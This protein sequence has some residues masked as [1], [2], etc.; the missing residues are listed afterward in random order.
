MPSFP[1]QVAAKANTLRPARV[2]LSV[3]VAPFYLLGLIVGVVWVLVSWS[4]AAVMLG[5]DRVRGDH[6]AD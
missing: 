5:V 6:G 1:A 4:A 3:L 2:A